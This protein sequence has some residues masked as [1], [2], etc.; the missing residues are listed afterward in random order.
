MKRG[1][2]RG[3]LV[4]VVCLAFVAGVST[5][6]TAGSKGAA[7][8]TLDKCQKRKA[9]VPFNHA[10]HQGHVKCET[11]HHKMEKGKEVKGCFEC[12]KCKK[13]EAPSATKAFHKN[14]KGC[15]K[16]E[17]K[18]PTKCSACHKK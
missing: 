7:T 8:Y 5:F 12:H 2:L 14:C 15:H 4:A 17:H 10:A 1:L 3:A 16:K 6:V 9:P 13:G 11:C 18:G